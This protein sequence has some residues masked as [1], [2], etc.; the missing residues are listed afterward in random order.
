MCEDEIGA[1]D[2]ELEAEGG[3]V[4]LGV[5]GDHGAHPR[6][7]LGHQQ[8]VLRVEDQPGGAVPQVANGMSTVQ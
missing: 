7:V 5:P 8:P 3:V 4:P 1:G 6:P 2:A